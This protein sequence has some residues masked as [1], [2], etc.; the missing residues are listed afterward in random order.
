MFNSLYGKG[1]FL[2]A[3]TALTAGL[4]LSTALAEKT[5]RPEPS[6]VQQRLQPLDPL[7]PEEIELVTRIVNADPQVKETLGSG[8]RQ[9]IVVQFLALKSSAYRE[10]REPEQMTIGRHAAVIFYRYDIDQGV[11]VIVDL[12][13]KA[14]GE[15]TKMEGKAVP[16]GADE[17]TEAF[18]LALR[19]GRVK[20]LL[21]PQVNEFRVAGLS[22]GDRPE[23]RVEGLR[24]VATSSTDPCYRHRCLDLLFRRRDGYVRGTSVTVDL[25]VQTVRVERIVR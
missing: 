18:N 2:F 23:N 8:R 5:R 16:L 1:A 15:I 21:G 9:L 10:A 19:D 7:T 12:E 4:L 22:S 17:V 11:H 20:A 6:E 14:V 13:Q 3:I 24:V 25:S